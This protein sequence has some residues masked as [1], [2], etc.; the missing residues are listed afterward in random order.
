MLQVLP[1]RPLPAAALLLKVL[2]ASRYSVTVRQPASGRDPNATAGTGEN[3]NSVETRSDLDT[4]A[5]AQ[6]IRCWLLDFNH[7]Q[8]QSSERSLQRAQT[9]VAE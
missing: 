4:S 6:G 8:R 2:S 1:A 7:E 5:L 9:R 3:T